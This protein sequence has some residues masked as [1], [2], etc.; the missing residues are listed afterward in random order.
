MRKVRLSKILCDV[1]KGRINKSIISL[2]LTE[3]ERNENY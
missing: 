1:T 3:K 2:Q